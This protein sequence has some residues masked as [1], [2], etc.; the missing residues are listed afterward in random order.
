MSRPLLAPLLASSL[1]FT[2]TSQPCA[3]SWAALAW[4]A[5]REGSSRST[6]PL[7]Q[8]IASQPQC[9]TLHL[10]F[11]RW[12]THHF[13]LGLAVWGPSLWL[14]TAPL[15]KREAGLQPL[16]FRFTAQNARAEAAISAVGG[17][18]SVLGFCGDIWEPLPCPAVHCSHSRACALFLTRGKN[19]QLWGFTFTG[20]TSWAHCAKRCPAACPAHTVSSSCWVGRFR[21]LTWNSEIALVLWGYDRVL[22]LWWCYRFHCVSFRWEA[23]K[24]AELSVCVLHTGSA[25]CAFSLSWKW[26]VAF[27]GWL[28]CRLIIHGV[29]NFVSCCHPLLLSRCLV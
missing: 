2:H 24:M 27:E 4:R 26:I 18:S 17:L 1:T 7:P 19:I 23:G 16:G 29:L 14:F 5:C 22:A 11:P 28:S 21:A 13:G 9:C 8:P 15:K 10:F 25:V 12:L 20:H 3:R 6:S